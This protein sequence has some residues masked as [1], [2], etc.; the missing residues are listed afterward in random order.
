M[1]T[2]ILGNGMI[3]IQC[4]SASQKLSVACEGREAAKTMPQD[5][6]PAAWCPY[7]E[8]TRERCVWMAA[9]EM[10]RNGR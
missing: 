8:G 1:T 9:F 6:T 7:L 3:T 4:L 2:L 5:F 10:E